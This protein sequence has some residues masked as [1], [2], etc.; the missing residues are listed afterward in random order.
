VSEE[1]SG[2]QHAFCNV[3][4]KR[5][6]WCIPHAHPALVRLYDREEFWS[7]EK[8]FFWDASTVPA[9]NVGGPPFRD[10]PNVITVV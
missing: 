3:K 9:L 1:E 7:G 10:A 8:F 4:E 6:K 2:A 5:R